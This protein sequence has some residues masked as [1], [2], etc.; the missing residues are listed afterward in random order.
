MKK[1]N[2]NSK[3][4]FNKASVTELNE[5]QMYDVNGGTSPTVTSSTWCLAGAGALIGASIAYLVK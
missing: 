2:V 5:V 4:A 3:L 1:Q